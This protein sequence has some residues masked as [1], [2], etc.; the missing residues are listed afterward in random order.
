MKAFAGARRRA[1]VRFTVRLLLLGA[2]A[3]VASSVWARPGGGSSFKGGSSS[4]SSRGSSSSSS[5][6]SRGGGGFTTSSGGYSSG[7]SSGG[8]SGSVSGLAVLIFIGIIVGTFSSIFIA[9]PIVLWWSNRKG[10]S[11]HKDVLS[12]AA[13]AESIAAAP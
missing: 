2:F 7:Y 5:S 13:K 3:L 1:F 11:L 10:G 8:T 9:S 12:S 6:S 4:S